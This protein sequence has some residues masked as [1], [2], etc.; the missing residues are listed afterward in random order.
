MNLIRRLSKIII[1]A[2]CTPMCY[3]YNFG[4]GDATTVH[5]NA[6]ALPKRAK[7]NK[8]TQAKQ[9]FLML[10]GFRFST[11]QKNAGAGTEFG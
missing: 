10:Y 5:F 11:I 2:Q 6:P 3:W 8:T 4:S 9:E 1:E 7:I